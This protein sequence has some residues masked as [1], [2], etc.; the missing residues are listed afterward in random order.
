MA[1]DPSK[2]QQMKDPAA[3]AAQVQAQMQA[4]ADRIAR[5]RAAIVAQ[6]Q[7]QLLEMQR[8]QQAE[9]ARQAEL[10]AQ[11]ERQQAAQQLYIAGTRAATQSVAQSLQIL[12]GSNT[13][14]A[15]TAAMAQ[16]KRGLTGGART[17]SA[18]LRIGS[19]G[20]GSG[21]GPNLAV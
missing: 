19:V 4:E 8:Q 16:R 13:N 6:Q 9:V 15:P 14:Q 12:S 10:K 2:W 1:N 21:A 5:E 3:H 17:A 18:S 7:A 11:F 20:A